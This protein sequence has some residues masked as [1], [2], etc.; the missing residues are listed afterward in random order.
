MAS[1]VVMLQEQ[2]PQLINTATTKNS[3]S[4]TVS[5][6][7]NHFVTTTFNCGRL[8]ATF[9]V[10][11]LP[12]TVVSDRVLLA[13]EQIAISVEDNQGVTE[14]RAAT[15]DATM[16]PNSHYSIATKGALL[17]CSSSQRF[18]SLGNTDA[19]KTCPGL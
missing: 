12:E 8:G 19:T 16:F 9:A 14:I 3:V 4:E 10:G 15:P 1:P 13:S 6:L 5:C 7:Q 11:I 17:A 2:K 18:T